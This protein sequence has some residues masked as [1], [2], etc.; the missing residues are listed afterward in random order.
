MA[1]LTE[2]PMCHRKQKAKNKKCVKCEIDLVK[3]KNNDKV[4]YWI[5]YRLN[6]KQIWELIPP[7][8]ESGKYSIE[9]ARASDG[10]RR[11]QRKE[12]RL[13]ILDIK[14]ESTMTFQELTD[15]F[16]SLE[17]V[18]AKVYYWV[19]Q[20]HLKKFNKMYGNTPVDQIK[21]SDLENF[22]SKRKTEGKAFSTIDQEIMAVRAVIT[23]AYKDKKV[24]PDTLMTFRGV[25]RL[26]KKKNSNA[27]N[28]VISPEE[29]ERLCKNAALH[30]K[31]ILATG[32]YTGMREGEILSLTWDKVS[33]Q[34]RIIRLKAEDTKDKES[35]II[36][37]GD[38]LYSILE[39]QFRTV[40]KDPQETHVF[41]YK[42]KPI[43]DIRTAL[44]EACKGAGIGYG[45]FK[46]GGFVFHDLRHTFVTN[47]RK[48]GMHDGVTMGI[49]GHSTE[50]MRKRYD[51]IDLDDLRC[52]IKGLEGFLQSVN[53]NVNKTP[54][55]QEKMVSQKTANPLNL[56]GAEGGTRT[57]TGV[58]PLDP[59][60][61]ASTN[62]ATSAH[63]T[64][65][66]ENF[67]LLFYIF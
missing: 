9:D 51:R 67:K 14:P 6:G 10:K 32:Y 24:G 29:Y 21:H 17:Y 8:P 58:T 34:D 22:K 52:G 16:L 61:S 28:R 62:S 27:R 45:R 13:S 5:T 50:E 26:L 42:G 7:N 54:S 49:T 64:K 55:E 47:M 60:S 44:K 4:R 46:D 37:I 57:P 25:E 12:K 39:G 1:V 36:P 11:A 30:L 66:I 33:L 59:E 19:L 23:A 35:R 65:W 43:K 20:I 40:P 15:W 63:R 41:L 38:D 2:C 48:A 31:S 53:Q 18:K 56:R 3:Q